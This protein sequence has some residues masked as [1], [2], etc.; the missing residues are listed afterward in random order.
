M[1]IFNG[2]LVIRHILIPHRMIFLR[3][4][5]SR[6]GRITFFISFKGLS[7]FLGRR[8]RYI[9][10]IAMARANDIMESVVQANSRIVLT[11]SLMEVIGVRFGAKRGDRIV[12][13]LVLRVKCVAR[14]KGR[15]PRCVSGNIN[16]ALALYAVL[17]N[18]HVVCRIL[19]A[20]PV[21]KGQRSFLL[22]VM[23]RLFAK[24]VFGKWYVFVRG[25]RNLW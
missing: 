4:I 8:F 22:N 13:R 17:G 2:F 5:T 14:I 11:S 23:L 21:F 3:V 7:H 10:M 20:P 12:P 24:W 15:V 18:R 1:R 16:A 25:K 9:S 6:D 19:G